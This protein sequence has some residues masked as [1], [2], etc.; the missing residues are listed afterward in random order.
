[1]VHGLGGEPVVYGDGLRE[2]VGALAGQLSGVFDVAGKTPVEELIA[3]VSSPRKVVTIANFGAGDS[4]IQMTSGESGIDPFASL[5]KVTGLYR[6]GR[7]KVAVDEVLPFES[8]AAAFTVPTSPCSTCRCP[9]VTAPRPPSPSPP[10]IPGPL[11]HPH[12]P[13]PSRGAQAGTRRRSGRCRHQDRP[14]H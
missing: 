4:G 10:S 2:R 13:R 9:D 5:A 14:R 7:L 11:H 3:I 1:M 6:D 8:A 12:P